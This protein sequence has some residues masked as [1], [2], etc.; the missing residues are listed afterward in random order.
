MT[1]HVTCTLELSDRHI[2]SLRKELESFTGGTS[3]SHK[4][5]DVSRGFINVLRGLM[6]GSSRGYSRFC[7][8]SAAAKTTATLASVIQN[9]TIVIAGVT[10]TARTSAANGTT[11]FT[12]GVSN[13]A[14]AASLAACIMA[15]TTLN[16]IVR[17]TSAA[18]VV[19]ITCLYPGPIGNS[20]TVTQTGGTITLG[21]AALA[22]GASDTVDGYNFGYAPTV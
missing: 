7:V 4:K 8:A 12:R 14:D 22:S 3:R 19:T 5:R 13:T 16:K 9:D 11:Q 15:N 17:A 18:A 20:V 10:L 6:S 21:A 2:V 1:T